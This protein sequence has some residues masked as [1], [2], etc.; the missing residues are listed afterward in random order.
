MKLDGQA[1]K[2][3]RGPEVLRRLEFI[4]RVVGSH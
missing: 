4:L 1:G 2:S 3:P